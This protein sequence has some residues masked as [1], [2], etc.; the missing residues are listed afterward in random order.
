MNWQAKGVEALRGGG[1]R[2]RGASIR[3]HLFVLIGAVSIPL[4]VLA[5]L[6][7]AANI[8]AQRRVIEAARRDVVTSL[9][10]LLD[11]ELAG[12]I[13]VAQ[14]LADSSE[15]DM[16]SSPALRALAVTL[17]ETQNLDAIGV[18]DRGGHLLASSLALDKPIRRGDMAPIAAAF[19]GRVAISGFEV[20]LATR[21]LLFLVSVPIRRNGA[22]ASVVT[23]GVG[24]ERLSGLFAKAGLREGWVG[25]I[26]DRNGRLLARSRSDALYLGKNATPEV[27]TIVQSAA[28]EGVFD[29][30]T[31]DGVPVTN[32]FH[33]SSISG[34]TSVV[35]VP[36]SEVDATL[37]RTVGWLFPAGAGLIG[38]SLLFASYI[39][40]RITAPIRS[41]GEAARALGEGRGL[42]PLVDGIVDFHDVAAAFARAARLAQERVAIE[43]SMAA[44][45]RRYREAMSVGKMGS[46]ETDLQA[47]TRAWTP[48]GMALFG[49]SLPG[50]R[51]Q[52]GGEDD[53]YLAALHPDDR[54]LMAEQHAIAHR[55]DALE[56]EYRVVR[57]D[58]SVRCLS[59]H[60]KVVSRTAD[61][62][63]CRLVNVSVDITERKRAEEHTLL[64]VGE[65]NHRAKNLLGVVQAIIRQTA[66]R[67]DPETFVARLSE[68]VN[69]LSSS[70]DLLAE[71]QW[72]G[73]GVADLVTG[74]L[75][76]FTDIIGTRVLLDGPPV[77]L[78]AAAAQGIGMALHE[79]ATNAG[80]YG[81]LSNPEGRVLISWRL[82]G[83]EKEAFG[84]SWIEEGGPAVVTPDRKGF[85]HLVMGAMAAASVQGTAEVVFHATGIA[86]NLSAPIASTVGG[87]AEFCG[88]P[89][90]GGA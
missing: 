10:H 8:K 20:G 67:G 7:G 61:G 44:S 26:V 37:W 76:G 41:L 40:R 73:V 62:R 57:P 24:L 80:K 43:L 5:A 15:I 74:Q 88:L 71:N 25:A 54:H 21:R 53:E 46:W 79:L 87:G 83:D 90:Q 42:P 39:A 4:L 84:M 48:E 28:I 85:G 1:Q 49:L 78:S 50:G 47:R 11:Q 60:G 65:I 2:H 13:A 3:A 6:L 81:A 77:L 75:A 58:G 35:A 68:R 86:W 31:L 27:V 82:S 16:T 64:L 18:F 52:V 45:D 32:A 55:Q 30:I 56:M 9:D 59:G 70:H 69:G 34:W 63:A 66:R 29:S 72:Q 38:L 12:V 19:E 17:S 23:A 51:G 22:I 36:Q 33:R 14:T 89:G